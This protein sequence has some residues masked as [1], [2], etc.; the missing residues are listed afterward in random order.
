MLSAYKNTEM[1]AVSSTTSLH[2]QHLWPLDTM[3][4]LI[5]TSCK[6]AGNFNLSVAQEQRSPPTYTFR[7]SRAILTLKMSFR[8]GK[9]SWTVE[10]VNNEGKDLIKEE[11]PGNG[12]ECEMQAFARAIIAGPNSS[13]AQ[14]VMA[15]TGPRAALQDVL[16]IEAALK[17]GETGQWKALKHVQADA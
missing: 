16:F 12:V 1:T 11:L 8:D 17:S 10:T 15:K 14:E 2:H 4:G 7:G 9:M 3:Q 5:Q 13:E 6:V